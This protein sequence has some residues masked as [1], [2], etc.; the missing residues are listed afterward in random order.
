MF[1]KES[2]RMI[3]SLNHIVLILIVN[4]YENTNS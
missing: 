3:P 4:A 2:A 1:R